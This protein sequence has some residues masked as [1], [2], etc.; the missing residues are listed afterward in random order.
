MKKEQQMGV[1]KNE[2]IEKNHQDKDGY[3]EFVE[4]VITF[5]KGGDWIRIRSPERDIDGR[6]YDC[7]EYCFLNL[8]GVA[9]NYPQ[10]YSVESAAGL[11]ISNGSIGKY[12][13]TDNESV[14]TFLSRDGGLNWFEIRKGSHIYEIG[15]HGALIL[16][17]DNEKPTQEIFYSWDEGLT[18]EPL[19]ISDEK[20]LIKNII[21]EPT[22]TSQHFI[23]Y[24]Y[25]ESKG[26]T[27]GIVIGVDFSGLHEPQCRNPDI[28]DTI[29]SDYEKWTPN[30]G[31]SGKEC[32]M[33]HKTI[34]IRRK[35]ESKCFNGQTFEK[36]TIVEHCECSEFDYECD[37]GFTRLSPGE[38]CVNVNNKH[39]SNNHGDNQSNSNHNNI[40]VEILTPPANCHGYYKI[41]K[42]YRKV[43]GNT[44]INGIKFDPILIPCP[45]SG[46]FAHL[47]VIFFILI[48][49][50]LITFIFFTINKYYYP[51]LSNDFFGY[52]YG[53]GNEN[54]SFSNSN[55]AKRDYSDIV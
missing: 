39:N 28:P 11:I 22:S 5:N 13:N 33:G 32:H 38:P 48:L 55:K 14:S 27:H 6:K 49:L 10:F 2:K 26:N 52:G 44:C 3:K 9:S 47:G 15:D 46:L 54:Y 53:Y 12:L 35:R 42:G 20:F 34:Y 17:A 23:I 45:Y 24:G 1:E 7:G 18:F 8:Y 29:E 36:K 43:P 25:T 4:T 16:I 41:S 21:I 50:V 31:R 51:I 19:R 30:D 40:D 37:F